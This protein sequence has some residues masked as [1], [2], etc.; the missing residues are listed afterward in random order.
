MIISFFIGAGSSVASVYVGLLLSPDS[1]LQTLRVESSYE[2]KQPP[3]VQPDRP[4][5]VLGAVRP[6]K[7]GDYHVRIHKNSCLYTRSRPRAGG[8][9]PGLPCRWRPEYPPALG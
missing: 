7:K 3:F 1:L 2:V 4:R 6:I 9:R 5:P 8:D